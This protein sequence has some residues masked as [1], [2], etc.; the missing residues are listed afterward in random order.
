MTPTVGTVAHMDQRPD[1]ARS[2]GVAAA[3]YD[4]HRPSYPPEAM[5]WA[6]GA[7]PRTVVDLG[8]GT[9]IMSR[10]LLHLGHDV[11][12]VE[13]DAAMRGRLSAA[14]PDV[15]C[16]AG[17]AEA[18]PLADASV[19]AVVAAQAYHWFDQERAH[20]EIA[21]VLRASGPFAPVWNIRDT[22]IPW[23][24]DLKRL[25]DRLDGA[26][27][28]HAGWHLD[29]DFGPLF[30]PIERRVFDHTMRLTADDVVAMIHTRS[31][32]LTAAPEQRAQFDGDLRD[33]L[34]D[35]PPTFDVPYK[36]VAYR[37]RRV[38]GR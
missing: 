38:A 27:G 32:Y 35:H 3:A 25:N 1:R 15:T 30:T 24:A 6:L 26:V 12:A 19:D 13:P 14:S 28:T 18:I 17:S 7:Q 4:V 29:A 23:V 2:F 11:I 20:V 21:R 10:L 9:G 34:A 33:L 31:S 8:A 5:R 16:L 22:D 37:A 36:T